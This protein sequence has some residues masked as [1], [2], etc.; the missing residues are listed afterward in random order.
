MLSPI[1]LT[2]VPYYYY[3]GGASLSWTSS[4]PWSTM[5]AWCMQRHVAWVAVRFIG[6]VHTVRLCMAEAAVL[7]CLPHAAN[8]QH[9]IG[10]AITKDPMQSS[11]CLAM[12]MCTGAPLTVWACCTHLLLLPSSCAVGARPLW[13]AVPAHLV[14]RS[15]STLSPCCCSPTIC[16]QLLRGEHLSAPADRQAAQVGHCNHSRGQAMLDCRRPPRSGEH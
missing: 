15:P 10:T 12:Q 16:W 9:E 4:Q 6:C 8:N 1:A 11:F 5:R 13:D 7:T 14:V 2:S 3:R